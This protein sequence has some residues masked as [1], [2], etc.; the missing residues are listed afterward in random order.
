MMQKSEFLKMQI[1]ANRVT[2]NVVMLFISVIYI[3]KEK[4]I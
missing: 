4:A 2:Y 3:T 1:V